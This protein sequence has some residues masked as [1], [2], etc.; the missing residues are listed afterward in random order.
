[1]MAALAAEPTDPALLLSVSKH[2]LARLGRPMLELDGARRDLEKRAL[3]GPRTRGWAELMVRLEGDPDP[4]KHRPPLPAASALV[5]AL[6]AAVEHAQAPFLTGGDADAIPAVR[7]LAEALE[8]VASDEKGAPGELWAGADG[9]QAASLF[10][11]LIQDADGLPRLTRAGFAELM[12]ELVAT[13]VVRTGGAGH[14]RLRI[15]GLIEARLNRADTTVLAGLEE[16]VWPAAAV[17]DPLLSRGMRKTLGLPSPERRIGAA[18]HD[19]AQAACGPRVT[20]IT[21]ERRA[22]SPA[23]RS[24]WLWRL[25]ML[26]KGA[27]LDLPGRPEIAAWAHAL[28]APLAAPPA[29]LKLADRPKPRPPVAVRPRRL[30]ATRVEEWIRD[31]YAT[32]AR[33]ILG[34][35]A[36]DPP[37]A[38]LEARARG[39]AIHAAFER[40][41]LEHPDPPWGDAA[42]FE[43][44]LL[45]SLSSAG[46]PEPGL[47]RERPLAK[48]LGAWAATLEQDR[49]PGAELLIEKEGT[50]TFTTAD[51]EFTLTAKADRLE[52]RADRIDVIDFK[53]GGAASDKEVKVGL[54]PQLTLT[55]AIAA[56][57]GFAGAAAL[58]PGEL[59]YAKVTGRR[60]PGELSIRAKGEA[61]FHAARALARLK[62]R[63]QAFEAES[64][65][66]LAKQQPKFI[67]ADGRGDYDHLMRLWEWRVVGEG[68]DEGASE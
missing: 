65:P 6:Q 3:R 20:L 63:V 38:P 49:R 59:A 12:A 26:A 17:T 30:A 34:L 47:A 23:T 54:A 66:Y 50:L 61:A 1:M 67:S 16:G 15:L 29:P 25:Q 44:M 7:A 53:S 14:P 55:A 51:G 9:E 62:E 56:E 19:F 46:L 57:G 24:R 40:F 2:A 4:A 45:E 28:E 18:A 52:V 5:R 41:A 13:E 37:D 58:P 11:G 42:T 22:G 21:A 32:Y 36:M 64:T 35:K 43:R 31:P 68:D 33:Y 10:A 8:L 39:T 48:R 60:T 27:G